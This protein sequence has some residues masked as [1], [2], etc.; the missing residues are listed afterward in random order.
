MLACMPSLVVTLLSERSPAELESLRENLRTEH[1]RVTVE[2]EQ[3]EAAIAHQ[4]RA[5]KGQRFGAGHR[6]KT[7]S[8]RQRIL[9]IVG[10][11]SEPVGPAYIRDAMAAQGGKAPKG[12]SIYSMVQRMAREGDLLK[13]ADGQ[14]TL[15]VPNGTDSGPTENGASARLSSAVAASEEA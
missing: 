14:Y 11:S 1:A 2:L 15:P 9:K 5:A 12:G 13:I 8:T 10:A 3:V 4:Q 7:G 6:R